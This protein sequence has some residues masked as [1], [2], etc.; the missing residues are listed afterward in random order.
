MQF[1]EE[2]KLPLISLSTTL[3]TTSA[4]SKP[5]AASNFC[6]ALGEAR[7][8]RSNIAKLPEFLLSRKCEE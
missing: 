4:P 6:D 7:R 3:R 8:I 1:H 2:A 5:R